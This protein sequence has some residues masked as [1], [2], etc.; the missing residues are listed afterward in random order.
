MGTHVFCIRSKDTNGQWSFVRSEE[1]EVVETSGIDRILMS[2]EQID[3]YD[4][5]GHKVDIGTYSHRRRLEK[6]V[7]I[8]NGRKVIVK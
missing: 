3:V 5:S 1:I 6:G 2:D 8:I 4:L 7:Y